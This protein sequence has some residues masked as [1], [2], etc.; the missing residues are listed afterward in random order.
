VETDGVDLTPRFRISG[1]TFDFWETLFM[2]TPE[3]DRRR[4]ELR[5]QGLQEN[6]AKMGIEIS[7]E[8]L[9]DGLRASTPW[10]ADIWKKGGQVSTIEQIR[11]IVNHATKNR[12]ILLIDPEV[13]IKLEESYWSPS[14]T[15]P[16]ALNVEAP[17]VLQQLRERNL[18]IG[19]VCNTGRGPGHALRELMRREGIL[20]YFDATVF[21]DEVG[22]G[23]PDPRIFLAAGEKLG[24]KPS[25]LLHVGDNIEND[26][27]GAQSAGMKALLFDYEVPSGFRTQHSLLALTRA[28][29]SNTTIVPDGRI[30]SLRELL[31][32]ID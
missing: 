20:D 19:L 25:N 12:A 16:A 32:F 21:S 31:N 26:V 2:D 9:G 28:S 10:L 17:E 14:L 3:L 7:F 30:K 5:C 24:L 6:L 22:Y 11:Y 13:L 27:G 4:D 29:D 18:Q 23:K 8:D 15:A 1:V